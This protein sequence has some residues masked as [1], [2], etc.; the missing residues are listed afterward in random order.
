MDTGLH[1][2]PSIPPQQQQQQQHLPSFPRSGSLQHQQRAVSN[3]A[4]ASSIPDLQEEEGAPPA[5]E[6]QPS[7]PGRSSRTSPSLSPR[8]SDTEQQ[9]Q[10]HHHEGSPQFSYASIATGASYLSCNMGH[11]ATDLLQYRR[12]AWAL[13]LPDP[14]ARRFSSSP[15]SSLSEDPSPTTETGTAT[16]T[17]QQQPQQPSS[18]TKTI[19]IWSI[20][21]SWPSRRNISRRRWW[22]ARTTRLRS[23]GGSYNG[24]HTPKRMALSWIR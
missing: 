17:Q 19:R 11:Q 18:R 3:A 7:P 21:W 9:Q 6:S 23:C 13:G 20:S 12:E 22:T 15:A 4:F 1:G 24:R 10:Q 16:T 2:A 14:K 5:P 8:T